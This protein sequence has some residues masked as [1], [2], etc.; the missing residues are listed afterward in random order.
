VKLPAAISSPTGVELDFGRAFPY[1]CSFFLLI[2]Y[3]LDVTRK[4]TVVPVIPVT[5][6][7]FEDY[8]FIDPS[9][10]E[11]E[12]MDGYLSCIINPVD[13]TICYSVMVSNYNLV[14]IMIFL[15]CRRNVRE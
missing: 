14:I 4:L 15:T 2:L 6:G 5:I 12:A 1:C 7:V 11:E 9:L 8:Y 13:G 3:G 10:Q